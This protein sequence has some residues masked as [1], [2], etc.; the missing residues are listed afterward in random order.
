MHSWVGI[1]LLSLLL[2]NSDA[3]TGIIEYLKSNVKPGTPVIVSDLYNKV[4]TAPEERKVLD[5]LFNTFF[6]IPM[7]IVQY[8]TSSKKIPTLQEISEQ[9]SFKVA[10][11]ADVMLRIMESDP[12]VPKFLSRDAKTG[13]ITA[14][15]IPK[16][17]ANPQFGR[18]LERSITGWE[19]RPSPPFAVSTYDG[20]S[21][22]SEQLSGQPYLIYFWF[23]NC[24]PCIK[25]S[26]LLVELHNQYSAKGFKIVAVNADR[27]LELPY[28]DKI[29]AD[30]VRTLGIKFSTA[31]LSPQ[32]QQAYGGVSVFPTLF[33][34]DRTGLVTKHFVNFQEK[35][36]LD[37]AIQSVLAPSRE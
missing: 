10:G 6:K 23:T 11:Q 27:V 17:Q 13:E 25:T 4:F 35:S 7:F 37:A 31:H 5:R 32:M 33:F 15:D 21:I 16:I 8:N 1:M 24:P 3:E 34:V 36:T 22:T 14:I 9:F 28:E 26:P 19:G 2:Q 20:G 12:R 30:Y 18:A 29:R